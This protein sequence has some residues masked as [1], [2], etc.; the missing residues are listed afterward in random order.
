MDEEEIIP[1]EPT[2]PKFSGSA[3]VLDAVGTLY[4]PGEYGAEGEVITAPEVLPG[5]H[6]NA[7]KPVAEW[8]EF[9]V[10]PSTP[11]RGFSG[12][13]TYYYSF[14]DEDEFNNSPADLDAET[15][16]IPGM[17]TSW[18][19]SK[20]LIDM[21]VISEVEAFAETAE[22]PLIKYGWQKATSYARNDPVV[23]A[24]QAG[25]GWTDEQVD[26]L[27]LVASGL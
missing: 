5:Y 21:G 15:V 4:T 8:A 22:N 25:L 19:L 3:I 26:Q 7:T 24:A 27:F 12:C 16:Q 20:A 17:I 1:Q 13:P 11:R 6:I 23:L 9:K 14:A 2:W 18:Q 10:T